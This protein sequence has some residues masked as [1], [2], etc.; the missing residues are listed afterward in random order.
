MRRKREARP[1]DMNF[2]ETPIWTLKCWRRTAKNLRPAPLYQNE[3]DPAS[4]ER[5]AGHERAAHDYRHRAQENRPR[6]A[7]EFAQEYG[8]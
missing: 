2:C 5:T 8:R 1:N 3:A 6:D 4:S 7:L